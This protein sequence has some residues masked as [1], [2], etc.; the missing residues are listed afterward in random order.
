M[1]GQNKSLSMSHKLG[2]GKYHLGHT[3]HQLL[4][5][6]GSWQY[7][8]HS[9]FPV[10]FEWLKHRGSA[11]PPRDLPWLTQ[12]HVRTFS[13]VLHWN[14]PLLNVIPLLPSW[15]PP[16]YST[17]SPMFTTPSFYSVPVTIAS[18]FFWSA[19]TS[20]RRQKK[21]LGCLVLGEVT[22]KTSW[23]NYLQPVPHADKPRHPLN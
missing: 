16:N 11:A 23:A 2:D 10:H 5:V 6:Q 12:L 13:S 3:V 7:I 14:F 21:A 8:F 20:H 17:L 1:V 4:P 22:T 18:E 9:F 15:T 19:D